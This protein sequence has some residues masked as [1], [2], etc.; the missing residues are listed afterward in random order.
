[1]TPATYNTLGKSNYQLE[2]DQLTIL[3]LYPRLCN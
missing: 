1:M 3:G 2:N